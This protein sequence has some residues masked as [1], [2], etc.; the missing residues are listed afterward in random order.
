LEKLGIGD[1]KSLEG[2]RSGARD[3]PAHVDSLETV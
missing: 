3:A 2:V 1:T